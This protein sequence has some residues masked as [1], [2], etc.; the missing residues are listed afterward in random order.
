MQ[1]RVCIL[2]PGM[3]LDHITEVNREEANFLKRLEREI[4][5]GPR[6]S[7]DPCIAVSFLDDADYDKWFDGTL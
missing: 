1:M 5:E 6:K 2:A 7:S 4:D 3:H